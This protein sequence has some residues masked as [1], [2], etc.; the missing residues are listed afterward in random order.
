MNKINDKMNLYL[1]AYSANI[2]WYWNGIW[3]R[4]G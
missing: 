3:C 4:N 2:L 1:V